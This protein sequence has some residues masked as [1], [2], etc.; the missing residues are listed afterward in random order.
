ME[1]IGETNRSNF[2]RDYFDKLVDK[3][4]LGMTLPNKPTSPK[5]KYYSL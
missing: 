4:V 2:K 3:K 1:H 5:Q